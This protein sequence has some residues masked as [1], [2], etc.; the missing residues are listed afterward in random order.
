MLAW[1]G[2]NI[3]VAGRTFDMHPN[4][5]G[6]ASPFEAIFTD[7]VA[8]SALVYIACGQFQAHCALVDCTVSIAHFSE[9]E[10]SV[11]SVAHFLFKGG[12]GN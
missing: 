7:E 11:C 1:W 5:I 12:N 10:V 8:F 3:S 4:Q 2:W 6:F 9:F